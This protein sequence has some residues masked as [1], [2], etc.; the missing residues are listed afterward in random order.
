MTVC[1]SALGCFNTE[2]KKPSLEYWEVTYEGKKDPRKVKEYNPI[3][4]FRTVKQSW[5]VHA[6]GTSEATPQRDPKCEDGWGLLIKTSPE[7][8]EGG[9]AVVHDNK[10]QH[11]WCQ[12]ANNR[13]GWAIEVR[14][15]ILA[16]GNKMQ[17]LS[18][19]DGAYEATLSFWPDRVELHN[20]GTICKTDFRNT[21]RTITLTGRGNTL[22]I[23]L[24]H[25]QIYTGP[26]SGGTTRYGRPILSFGDLLSWEKTTGSTVIWDYVKYNT[27]GPFYTMWGFI[28]LETK[29]YLFP[30]CL[31]LAPFLLYKYTTWRKDF[32]AP[33]P[34]E[35]ARIAVFLWVYLLLLGI[36]SLYLSRDLANYVISAA[37]VFLFSGV[38]SYIYS[39]LKD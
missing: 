13:L 15:K 28:A 26:F 38:L 21:F 37:Y 10:E 3:L 23:C 8:E 39:I 1:L 5:S 22:Q 34:T 25:E 7:G 35:L 36:S 4:P 31:L 27:L 16:P 14:L 9:F 18:L 20:K 19:D 6:M 29:K 11:I 32:L 12:E 24:D 30:L 17:Q 33:S 2:N